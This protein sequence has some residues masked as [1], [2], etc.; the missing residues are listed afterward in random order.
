MAWVV[1]LN[2]N[3]Q[4]VYYQLGFEDG[5]NA[6]ISWLGKWVGLQRSLMGSVINNLTCYR[7]KFHLQ[8]VCLPMVV[9]QISIHASDATQNRRTVHPKGIN[10]GLQFPWIQT[11]VY[12]IPKCQRQGM[13]FQ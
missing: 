12:V 11:S 5:S 10:P 2:E 6:Q 3:C 9:S 1:R 7:L 4:P 8:H 13:W